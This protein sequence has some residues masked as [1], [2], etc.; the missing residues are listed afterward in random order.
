[1]NP[2]NSQRGSQRG[3]Q[4]RDAM[5]CV[6]TTTVPTVVTTTAVLKIAILG[7]KPILTDGYNGVEMVGHYHIF[8]RFQIHIL[9]YLERLQPFIFHDSPNGRWDQFVVRNIAEKMNPTICANGDKIGGG[10][11][12]IPPGG[13]CGV[14][15]EFVQIKV[16]HN[17]PLSE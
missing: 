8:T 2:Y 11:P 6:S 7:I 9:A 10:I 4:R 17:R 13:A 12:I 14:N 1:K 16:P 5:H 15:A 3:S